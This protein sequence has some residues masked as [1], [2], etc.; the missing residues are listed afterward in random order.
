M[1]GRLGG[2]VGRGRGEGGQPVDGG[3]GGGCQERRRTLLAPGEGSEAEGG[4]RRVAPEQGQIPSPGGESGRGGGRRGGG[5]LRE[6]RPR[7]RREGQGG[8]RGRLQEDGVQ[9]AGTVGEVGDQAG[10]DGVRG[11]SLEGAQVPNHLS[12]ALP[13]AQGPVVHR[14][15]P[16]IKIT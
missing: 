11:L 4:G 10:P 5:D 3:Q 12:D 1:R 6:G 8:G 2:S 15:R 7:P 16:R 9:L 13:E 14:Q